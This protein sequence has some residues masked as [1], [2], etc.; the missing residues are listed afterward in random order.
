[1]LLFLV[2]FSFQHSQLVLI[3]TGYV[4]S[5]DIWILYWHHTNTVMIRVS[6]VTAVWGHP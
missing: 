2:F 4:N 3:C 1:M 6:N 5:L